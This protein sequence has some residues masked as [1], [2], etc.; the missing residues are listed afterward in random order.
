MDTNEQSDFRLITESLKVSRD[1]KNV[2]DTAYNDG[3]Q[4]GIKEVTKEVWERNMAQGRLEEKTRNIKTAL[5]RNRLSLE[6][7][8]EDFDTTL[9]FVTQIKQRYN[10]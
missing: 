9:E 7:I 3:K 4:Q 2:I 8:V 5:I 1:L 10:L 6:E